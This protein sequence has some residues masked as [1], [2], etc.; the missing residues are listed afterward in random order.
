MK[1]KPALAEAQGVLSL[2]H[3][4]VETPAFMPVGTAGSVKAMDPRDLREVDAE[5]IL[6]NTY[7]LWVRPGHKQIR[8]LGGLHGFMNWDGPILTDSGGFQIFSL[9]KILQG[10]RRR[11]QV[12]EQPGWSVAFLSPNWPSRFKSV[13]VSMSLWCWMNALSGRRTETGLPGRQIARLV[14]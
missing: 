9:K 8:T 1:K 12:S 10:D 3:G 2:P 6:A 5:M 4:E 13:S 11:L 7:H 14:G